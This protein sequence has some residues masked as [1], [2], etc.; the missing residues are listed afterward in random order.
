MTRNTLRV[1]AN[2]RRAATHLE[3]GHHCEALHLVIGALKAIWKETARQN[4]MLNPSVLIEE[5]KWLNK[6]Q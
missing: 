6:I 4:V 1:A 2:L 3:Q 5:V